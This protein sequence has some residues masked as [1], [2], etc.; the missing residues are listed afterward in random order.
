MKKLAMV[1]INYNDYDTT[2]KLIDNIKNYK[3][4]DKI[5]IVDNASTDNSYNK[6]KKLTNEKI[7]LIRTD[8]NKGYA[9]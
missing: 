7:V 6:L 1:I 8:D 4:L 2:K 5:I 3:V 9:K